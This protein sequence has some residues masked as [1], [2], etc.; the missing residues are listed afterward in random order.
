MI[1]DGC[2]SAIR[3]AAATAWARPRSS[4]STSVCPWMRSEAF[5]AVW[6]WR[7]MISRVTAGSCQVAGHRVRQVP[8][9][10]R[11]ARAVLPEPV[12]RVELALLAVEDVHHD[13]DVVEK[14]PPAG[15]L[16]LAADRL[17][18]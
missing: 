17:G 18:L 15:A 2:S 10:E 6:P 9:D 14:H 4:R 16:A 12:E 7:Q 8:I 13:V 1:T 5:H 3:A 11:D